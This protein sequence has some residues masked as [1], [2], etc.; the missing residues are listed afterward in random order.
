MNAIPSAA[1][2]LGLLP[3]DRERSGLHQR[4]AQQ[5]ARSFGA[6][7]LGANGAAM[8]LHDLGGDGEAEAGAAMLGGVEGQKQPFANFIGEAMAGVG[9]GNFDAT[10]SSLSAV[11]CRER[12][13]GCPAW[14]RRRC[15]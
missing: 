9:N 10:P 1:Q 14:L 2:G 8:F 6:V 4:H 13:T 5:K 11:Q 7:G 15:R 3:V 12:A